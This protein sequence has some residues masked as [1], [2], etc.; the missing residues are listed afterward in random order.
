MATIRQI[1]TIKIGTPELKRV[2]DTYIPTTYV[3]RCENWYKIGITRNSLTKRI[4][5]MRTGNPFPIHLVYA[6]QTENCASLE[7]A[8]HTFFSDR[9][10]YRE[11]FQLTPEDEGRLEQFVLDFIWP[12]D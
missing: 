7:Q 3:L 6:I 4:E 8:L 1:S 11:W 12:Q 9:P 2:L 10:R 5:N